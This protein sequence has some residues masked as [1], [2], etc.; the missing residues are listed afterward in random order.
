MKESVFA[1][2]VFTAVSHT[3]IFPSSA[4]KTNGARRC[5]TRCTSASTSKSVL[6]RQSHQ[7]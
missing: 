5:G 4:C 6:S 7:R 3:A 1:L 2:I